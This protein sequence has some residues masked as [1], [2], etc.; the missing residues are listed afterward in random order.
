MAERVATS[1]AELTQRAVLCAARTHLGLR[2]SKTILI[3]PNDTLAGLVTSHPGVY[4][5][6]HP[7]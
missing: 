4:G 5:L 6:P 1:R 2:A 7:G 3:V